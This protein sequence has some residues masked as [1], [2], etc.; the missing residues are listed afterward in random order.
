MHKIPTQIIKYFS[1][2]NSMNS[3]KDISKPK[4]IPEYIKIIKKIKQE[5]QKKESDFDSS[6]NP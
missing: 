6:Q 4:N 5:I 2:L 3:Q 1:L